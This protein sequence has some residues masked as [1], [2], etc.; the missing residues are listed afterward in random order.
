[1]AAARIANEQSPSCEIT[2][3]GNCVSIEKWTACRALRMTSSRRVDG[4]RVVEIVGAAEE[5]PS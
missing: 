1:M 5:G 2:H 3:R 4:V